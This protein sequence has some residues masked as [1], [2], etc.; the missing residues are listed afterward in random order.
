MKPIANW[1]NVQAAKERMVLPGGGFVVKIV[2]AK[3]SKFPTFERLDIALDISEGEYKGYYD[4]DFKSQTQEDKK[5]KGVLSQKLPQD[6]GSQDDEWKKAALK[7]LIEAIEESN[8]GYHW[9]WDETKLKGKT[10]G[11]L[12]RMEEWFMNGKKGWKARPFKFMP[13]DRIRQG[14]FTVPKFRPHRDFPGDTPD[15]YQSTEEAPSGGLSSF[16][17]GFQPAAN[18][19]E[20]LLP[21]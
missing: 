16:S 10:A 17:G 2:G 5:W 19:S 14:A 20:E 21:F 13:V 4:L 12:F 1:A 7:A 15:N 11:C 8:P 3:I 9:D 6:D 18:D